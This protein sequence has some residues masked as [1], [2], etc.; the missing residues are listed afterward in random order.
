MKCPVM[1][2]GWGLMIDDL[3][4]SLFVCSAILSTIDRPAQP[5]YTLNNTNQSIN[6]SSINPNIQTNNKLTVV[7]LA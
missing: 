7:E 5:L 1:K 2:G 4:V 6:Q 3:M